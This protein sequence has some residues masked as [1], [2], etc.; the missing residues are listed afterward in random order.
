[1]KQ[2]KLLGIPSLRSYK[3][4]TKNM[5]RR[6]LAKTNKTEAQI[7]NPDLTTIKL[8]E[9]T[10]AVYLQQ[11]SLRSASITHNSSTATKSG[12]TCESIQPRRM[13]K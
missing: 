2:D 4:T 5:E 13:R 10:I 6:I 11:K 8:T 9:T 12:I 1:M 7:Q 3:T